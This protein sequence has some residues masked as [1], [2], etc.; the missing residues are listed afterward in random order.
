MLTQPSDVSG[1]GKRKTP[2]CGLSMMPPGVVASSI[3]WRTRLH[4]VLEATSGQED[5]S[6]GEPDGGIRGH[7]EVVQRAVVNGGDDGGAG[8][9]RAEIFQQGTGRV[10]VQALGR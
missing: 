2:N 7:R 10:T 3:P 9:G 8:K 1:A 4:A 6:R 5:S